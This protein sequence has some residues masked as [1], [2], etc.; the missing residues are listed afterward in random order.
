MIVVVGAVIDAPIDDVW[1]Q[2]E[3]FTAWHV[4]IPRIVATTMQDGQDQA[5]VGSVRA[6]VREDGTGIRERLE[7]KDAARHTLSY[8]FDGPHP[9][10]VRRYLGTVRLEPITTT[11]TTYVHW[12]G[13]FDADAD[14][15]AKVA[16]TFRRLYTSFIEAIAELSS[17]AR[18]AV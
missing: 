8:S 4:W 16:D 1:R 15:E 14:A 10:P 17:G 5:P 7:M 9:F 6:L 11:G 3:D 12:S 18:A 2:I 13:D